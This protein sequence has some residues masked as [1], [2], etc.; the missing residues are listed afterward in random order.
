MKTLLNKNQDV[1]PAL[2]GF[3][4]ALAIVYTGL[5]NSLIA[6]LV[7]G[8]IPGTALSISPFIMMILFSVLAAYGIA[9]LSG[10]KIQLSQ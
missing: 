10:I 4:F 5:L 6:F 1:I 2:L 9:R 3:I 8:A 7:V